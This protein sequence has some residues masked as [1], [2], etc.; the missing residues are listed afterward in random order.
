MKVLI[1]DDEKHVR[2]AIRLL[3]D[4]QLHGINTVLEAADG[5]TA[6]ELMNR[7]RPEFVFTDMIM[8]GMH[9]TDLLEWLQVHAPDTKT[10]V[11]SG[12]DDFD[13]VRKTVKYGGL[14]YLL[15][16]I[17]PEQLAEAVNRV[18]DSYREMERGRAENRRTTMEINEIKPVYWDK[19][20]SQLLAEP[21][22]ISSMREPLDRE[23]KI[24]LDGTSC[25]IA[26]LNVESIS[27]SVRNKFATGL[28]LLYF[29]LL[30]ICN[31]FLRKS[32]RGYA[33]R[34]W[35]STSDIVLLL[36]KDLDD[37]ESL[38]R[39]IDKGIEDT[40]G[41]QGEF[42]LGS[43]QIAPKGLLQS[44][45]E[46]TTALDRRNLLKQGKKIHS[47]QPAT[48]LDMNKTV[49]FADCEQY[50]LAAVTGGNEKQVISVLGQWFTVIRSLSS[51]SMEQFK[52]W[53]NEYQLLRNRW[54]LELCPDAD[55]LRNSNGQEDR[56]SKIPL[57]NDGVLDIA[58]WEQKWALDL[59]ALTRDVRFGGNKEQHVIWKIEK[60][61]RSHYQTDL[62][63]Q[64]I[65]ER[66]FLSREY[67]SRRFKQE[68]GENLSDYIGRVRI[69]QAKLLLTNPHIRIAQIASMVGYADEKYFS[70]V[71]K[72]LTGC[73]PNDY[74]H[75]DGVEQ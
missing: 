16:P 55:S 31:E 9:G 71:F 59:T 7:E 42:G 49:Y 12:F 38:L 56:F 39:R 29:S 33:F 67:I 36:W 58:G 66:F 50:L 52:A 15:K 51:I 45:R 20:F 14:D 47:Y 70:K 48:A 25:R 46:A 63:L 57:T 60:Y 18:V 72:K 32:R 19:M 3:V 53:M 44:F 11:I 22:Y 40:L 75:R 43:V 8:P 17:D 5:K 4:W 1:V 74:R 6:I 34:Q 73:S 28:D 62:S 23:F 27:L 35:D 21:D 68:F 30:N 69:D 54:S 64:E 65:A 2:E 61:I 10:I 37:A 24:S 41:G 13:F 26:I